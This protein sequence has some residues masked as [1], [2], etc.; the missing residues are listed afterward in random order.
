METDSFLLDDCLALI[1]RSLF[2]TSDSMNDYWDIL[3]FSQTCSAARWVYYNYNHEQ[4]AN[5]LL[6]KG[7]NPSIAPFI[8][9]TG[10]LITQRMWLHK[11]LH[12]VWGVESN[13]LPNLT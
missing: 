2:L 1:F 3:H 9:V 4:L 10:T 5:S 7:P 6:K 12:C 8:H 11:K 13:I